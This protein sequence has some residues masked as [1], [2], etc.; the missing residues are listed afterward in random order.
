MEHN[1][2]LYTTWAQQE[3]KSGV[4]RSREQCNKTLANA[5]DKTTNQTARAQQEAET[6]QAA[7]TGEEAEA[8][9]LAKCNNQ[10]NELARREQ[11][12]QWWQYI[13]SQ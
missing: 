13:L 12:E 10:P 6:E 5:L 3:D 2:Q 9:K 11:Q 4:E 7:G 1:N 8:K